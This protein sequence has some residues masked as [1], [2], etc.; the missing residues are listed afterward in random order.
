MKFDK[1]LLRESL[2]IFPVFAILFFVYLIL[3]RILVHNRSYSLEGVKLYNML[4]GI[5]FVVLTV[6][7]FIYNYYWGTKFEQYI[8]KKDPYGKK[9]YSTKNVMKNIFGL[10][11]YSLQTMKYKIR[12]TKS[13]DKKMAFLAK[14]QIIGLLLMVMPFFILIMHAILSSFAKIII[15]NF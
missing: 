12:M 6:F 5:L 9:L 3:P 13:L 10:R 1:N 15:A 8:V 4:I 11:Y 2:Y 14:K 7:A